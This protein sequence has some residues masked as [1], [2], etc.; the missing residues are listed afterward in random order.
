ML[1]KKIK[2]FTLAEMLVTLALTSMMVSFAYLGFNQLGRLLKYQEDQ[3]YFITQFNE[4]QK[5]LLV[6]SQNDGKLYLVSETEF[7]FEGDSL[8]CTLDLGNDEI[9]M[10][11]G[12][13]SDTFHLKAENIKTDLENPGANGI[14]ALVKGFNC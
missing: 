12:N 14:P 8:H 7:L 2:A 11:Q 5:R 10:V 3:G 1:N 6:M 4:L 9:L 13:R